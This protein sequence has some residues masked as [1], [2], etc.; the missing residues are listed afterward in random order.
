MFRIAKF[1]RRSLFLKI[2][3]VSA[4]TSISLIYLAGSQLYNRIRD[5]IFE[6]KISSAVS[7]GRAAIQYME[8]RFSAAGLD[9][10][11]NFADL[12]REL[13]NSTNISAAE[14]GR[15]V[16]IFNEFGRKVGGIPAQVTSNYLQ[17]ESIP[18][19]L[20]K[21]VRDGDG[22]SWSRANL[23]YVN[24]SV[25]PGIFIG[26]M[27]EIPNRGSYEVYV[28]YDF[29]GQQKNVDLIGRSMWGTGLF[30]LA[31]ILITASVVLRIV[32]RPVQIAAE[33]ADSL[34][35]G[36][37]R[38][39]IEVSGEDEVARLGVAFNQ[40]ASALSDQISRL[41]NLSRVQQRF[42]SDVSHELRTPLTTIRMA[43]DLIYAARNQFDPTISRS[44]ELLVS[45]IKRFE[46]LLEDL[47]EVSRFDAEAAVL[48]IAPF[49]VASLVRRSV[50]D[51][52]IADE[53]RAKLIQIVIPNDSVMID[54]D[55]R[56]VER[57]I[58]NLL[59]NAIDHCEGKPIE[60]K[61]RENESAV[62]VGVRD[63]GIG[64]AEVNW[65]RVFDRFWRADPSRSRISGGTG[66]GL[67]IAR[68]DALLH[69][70]EIRLWGEIGNGA[71][72][73]LTLPKVP[74]G[75]IDA[76]PISEIPQ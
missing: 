37:L 57:I 64:I 22:L 1:F 46:H 39:R 42:V 8:Y 36:N 6:E 49:D 13:V 26:R 76:R 30:L 58:R 20:R 12:T 15:D 63:Y 67:S 70:G 9:S 68:E 69:G 44:A 59:N 2:F 43:A 24:G 71:N 29:V 54:G 75:L 11:I 33:V 65:N 38:R 50:E 25:S 74:H 19:E 35:A 53:T 5:G 17:A 21:K 31:L 61:L 10:K 34:T 40:M 51:L 4:L 47:L 66:L 52:R 28:G 56:R 27:I 41:E 48:S 14:S 7:E 18:L 16:A 23:S 32:I 73:V 55:A 62:S 3:A 72:F 60:I 45:Q